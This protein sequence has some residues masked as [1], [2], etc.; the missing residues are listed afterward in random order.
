MSRVKKRGS[1]KVYQILIIVLVAAILIQPIHAAIGKDKDETD[2]IPESD[3]ALVSADFDSP[4]VFT[5]QISIDKGKTYADIA[6]ITNIDRELYYKI[7]VTLPHNMEG[8]KS[9]VLKDILPKSMHYIN[10]SGAVHINGEAVT[11]EEGSLSFNKPS[12]ALVFNFAQD[13]DFAKLADA[14]I[15]MRLKALI[16]KSKVDSSKPATV[17]NNAQIIINGLSEQAEL[18]QKEANTA[19]LPVDL[20]NVLSKGQSAQVSGK[21]IPVSYDVSFTLPYDMKGYESIR[22][23]DVIP[24]GMS[25]ASSTIAVRSGSKDI[26]ELGKISMSKYVM[27]N[28]KIDFTIKKSEVGEE[29][30]NNL[31]NKVVIMK[32]KTFFTAEALT[33]VTYTNT[34]LLEVNGEAV[35][36]PATAAI[37]LIE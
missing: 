23:S 26:T 8:Y 28:D 22:I 4:V 20:N 34:A 17:T 30:W 29:V 31:A 32:V 35:G 36:E 37:E 12:N 16:I 27:P 1:L 7:T 25:I 11:A 19:E 15:E 3:A 14:T 33:D 5:E 10:K 6:T 24:V 2:V 9:A 18:K 21:S 13:Y